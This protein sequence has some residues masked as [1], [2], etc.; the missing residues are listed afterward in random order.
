MC[1]VCK[2]ESG[3]ECILLDSRPIDFKLGRLTEHFSLNLYLIR[4]PG[5]KYFISPTIFDDHSDTVEEIDWQIKF[6]PEC[7]RRL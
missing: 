7:G 1:K 4:M 6:C 2:F 3:N 5:G